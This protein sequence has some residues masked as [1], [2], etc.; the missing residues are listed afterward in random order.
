MVQRTLMSAPNTSRK[1]RYPKHTFNVQEK[2]F[3]LQPLGFARV[4]P[5]DTLKNL[6]FESRAVSNPILNPRIGWKKQYF[7]F[8]VR[9]T[10][11][12]NAAIRDLFVDPTNSEIT[13]GV[14]A[15]NAPAW[16]CAKGGV[17]WMKL[18][19]EQIVNHWFRDSGENMATAQLANGIPIVQIRQNSFLD[20]LTD[21]TDM[22]EGAA[23][24]TA[25]DAADLERLMELFEQLRAMNIADMTY[26]DWLKSNGINIPGKDENKPELLWQTSDFQYPTNHIG[27][28]ATNKGVP[29]S[30][31]SWVFN[32]GMRDPK[33]F[34]EPGFVMAF[35][36]TRPK[37]YWGGLF[38]SAAGFAK[39]A[40]DWAPNYMR[41]MPE[42][43][44]KSF[45][46]DTGPLGE[47]TTNA[48]GYFLD[49]VDELLYGDQWQNV[50]AIGADPL[51]D[52]SNH[53]LPLPA[54]TAIKW[55]YPTE[56]MVNSFFVDTINP[57]IK[58]DGYFS[59]SI[60]GHEVDHTVG[61]FAQV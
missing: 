21:V 19:T 45:A 52:P 31:L 49:M 61:N 1:G 46:V 18:G 3:T 50:S 39:R 10:D 34:R 12:L 58:Q 32:T 56:A 6:K 2:P 41:E 59:L 47:R 20:S 11:L 42:T 27:T 55:K 24:A 16:Y 29:T 17:N 43:R 7:F 36:V 8:Y 40:W 35:S 22:P 23:I 48:D 38:G 37:I 33:Q 14:E 9:I 13:A 26:E 5:G 25:T 51:F 28:D 15:A 30:A 53:M 60:M 4:L 44:L 54:G 57:Y